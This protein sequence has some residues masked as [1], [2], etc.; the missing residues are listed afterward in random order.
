MK[1][2]KWD[3]VAETECFYSHQHFF[4]YISTNYTSLLNYPLSLSPPSLSPL[5]L[6]FLSSPLSPPSLSSSPRPSLPLAPS[7][8]PLRAPVVDTELATQCAA[9]QPVP[10]FRNHLSLLLDRRGY[11]SITRNLQVKGAVIT[12]PCSTL[13]TSG[14]GSG[15]V[16]V[17][18]M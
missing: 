5:L 16:Y 18:D 6:P 3:R 15:E 14:R 4:K 2:L 12:W 17:I 7:S 11:P 13:S 8:L 1:E 10:V 9:S